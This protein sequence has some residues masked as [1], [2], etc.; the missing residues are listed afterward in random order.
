MATKIVIVSGDGVVQD[1]SL[2]IGGRAHRLLMGAVFEDAR[3]ADGVSD[4]AEGEDLEALDRAAAI[5]R[6]SLDRSAVCCAL[7]G[8]ATRSNADGRATAEERAAER[9][10]DD[11]CAR[12]AADLEIEKARARYYEA[13]ALPE[14]VAMRERIQEA[15]ARSAHASR[16]YAMTKRHA[17]PSLR[18]WTS[19]LADAE[20]RML[21]A[22][23]EYTALFDEYHNVMRPAALSA[24]G[25]RPGDI[26]RSTSRELRAIEEHRRMQLEC[27]PIGWGRSMPDDATRTARWQSLSEHER[28]HTPG[29]R[30]RS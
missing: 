27:Y 13:L 23:A 10:G 6:A 29:P 21:D 25:I 24:A 19:A 11:D 18:L 4:E 3:S 17:S 9:C 26:E 1:E 7:C 28:L 30:V 15:H 2:R 20:R 14:L 5:G 8:R 12:E 22:R 16:S